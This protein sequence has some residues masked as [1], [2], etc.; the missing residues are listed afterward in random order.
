MELQKIMLFVTIFLTGLQLGA[1]ACAIS[2]LPVMT[3]I[4][5]SQ[6]NNKNTAKKVLFQYFSGKIL[7]YSCIAS[8][9]F[10]GGTILKKQ[11]STV[12]SF[13]K[14]G[15]LVILFVGLLLLYNAIKNNNGCKTSCP[16][17]LKYGYF[18]IGF[19][20]SFSFCLPVISLITLSSLASSFP[21]SLSYGFIFGIG[22]TIIPF[23]FFY[24][25]IF[26]ITSTIFSEISNYK[27]QIE[28]FSASLLVLV[29]FLVYFEFL[30]L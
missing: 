30:K 21:L 4:L 5:L 17:S 12:I 3:P 8:I 29:A 10:F 18:S 9:S 26:H 23:L 25:F 16:A 11:I 14:M 22:V 27:K 6:Q 19:F 1:T 15:A 13:D 28:I 24:F 20:S 7:A 2:C